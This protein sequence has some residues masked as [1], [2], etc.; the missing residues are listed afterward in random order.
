MRGWGIPPIRRASRPDN[1][2]GIRAT[3]NIVEEGKKGSVLRIGRP[4]E[5]CRDE[6]RNSWV[7]GRTERGTMSF[8]HRK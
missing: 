4:V 3:H 7:R 2:L 6:S 8:D 5:K 1:G